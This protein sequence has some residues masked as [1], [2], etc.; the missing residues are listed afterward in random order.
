MFNFPHVCGGGMTFVWLLTGSRA[1]SS[2]HLAQKHMNLFVMKLVYCLRFY[3]IKYVIVTAM[4]GSV[5]TD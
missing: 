1:G 2:N 3:I 5:V 4:G